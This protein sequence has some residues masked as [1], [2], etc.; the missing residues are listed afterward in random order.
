MKNNLLY[1]DIIAISFMNF[2][3][4][5][6]AGNIIFPPMV[7]LQ[8]GKLVWYAAIGFLI[9]A[10][11]LPTISIIALAQKGG[12][13]NKLISPIGKFMGIILIT[14]CYLS[15]GPFF[16]I[17]RTA[18]VSFEINILPFTGNSNIYLFIYSII[19]FLIINIISL[20]PGKLL[21]TIGYFL[22]PLKTIALLILSLSIIF[23]QSGKITNTINICK[24][25]A[26]SNGIINGYL[27]MDTLGSLMFGNIIINALKSKG[28]KKIKKL[29]YY[30]IITSFISGLC[31]I[32]VYLNLF[33]LGSTSNLIINQKTNGIEILS[34]YVNNTFGIFGNF[35]LSF[36][37]FITC[38]VTSIGLTCS[39][40]EF[41][42]KYLP[43]SYNKIVYIIIIISILITNIGLDKLIKFFIPILTIIC[44]PCMVLIIMSF[45][46]NL[47]YKTNI[48]FITVITSLFFSFIDVIQKNNLI[49]IISLNLPLNKQELSWVTPTIFIF[50]I[51]ILYYYF[52]VIKKIFFNIKIFF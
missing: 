34:I 14:I 23:Y 33:K 46:S 28:I 7:G 21:N 41:F 16:A 19:Y 5:V 30:T 36:L 44:P 42:Y 3:L 15:V 2:A 50:F 45:L 39:C 10:T 12:S 43:I 35:F 47:F 26:F 20:Y 32:F 40:A 25:S 29:V 48:I 9:T 13:I 11:I 38:I 6:G 18:T 8:S 1:K 49:K 4:F 17:P 27:T 37:I 51:S 22:A 31:I 24:N 52:N